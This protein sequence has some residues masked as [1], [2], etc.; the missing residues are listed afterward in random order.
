VD[1]VEYLK[2]KFN[3]QLARETGNQK[4]Q[5]QENGVKGKPKKRQGFFIF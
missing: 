2:R 1:E 4:K 3:S 5:V